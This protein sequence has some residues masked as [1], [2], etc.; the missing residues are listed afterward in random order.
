MM[1]EENHIVNLKTERT[2][3]KSKI[4]C[5]A[6]QIK[7]IHKQSNPDMAKVK[8]IYDSLNDAYQVFVDINMQYEELVN[9]DE[10]YNSYIKVNNLTS[11][12]FLDKIEELYEESTTLY[13][14]VELSETTKVE[15][16]KLE[17]KIRDLMCFQQRAEIWLS[18]MDD[19]TNNNNYKFFDEIDAFLYE[20]NR[21]CESFSEF[22]SV[23]K[24]VDSHQMLKEAD[25]CIFKLEQ[26]LFVCKKIYAN[27]QLSSDRVVENST[28]PTYND[29]DQLSVRDGKHQTNDSS[30][31]ALN[32]NSDDRE[33]P[34]HGQSLIVKPNDHERVTDAVSNYRNMDVC[35]HSDTCDATASMRGATAQ[36]NSGENF[37]Y[38]DTVS[39]RSIV[40][41]YNQKP[42]TH[43]R[44]GA[45]LVS[46]RGGRLQSLG[47]SGSKVEQSAA[48]FQPPR[49]LFKCS[50]P[51]VFD[52]DRRQWPEFRSIWLRYAETGFSEDIDKAFALKKAIKGRPAE[53]IKAI[54]ANQPG[55]FQRM[56]DRLDAVYFDNSMCIQAAESDLARLRP[57]KEEDLNGLVHFINEVESIYSQLGEVDQLLSI[58][59]RQVDNLNSLLPYHLRREWLSIYY[60]LPEYEKVHPFSRFMLFLEGERDIVLRL[61]EHNQNHSKRSSGPTKII[62][63]SSKTFHSSSQ[64]SRSLPP[65]THTSV[66]KCLI[67]S[68]FPTSHDTVNCSEFKAMAQNKRYQVVLRGNACF[69]CLKRGHLRQN[70]YNWVKCKLCDSNTHHTLLCKEKPDGIEEKTSPN[71]SNVMATGCHTSDN[72]TGVLLPIQSVSVVDTNNKVSLF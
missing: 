48:A 59:L 63:S 16:K 42:M 19:D 25:E 26:K 35:K 22:V 1:A 18:R 61:S 68:N 70:C 50:A 41:A 10:K 5:H 8:D 27:N 52:G 39:R 56:W 46:S 66:P 3:L 4:T 49:S 28:L 62:Q 58:T 29:D 37:L 60:K 7:T 65:K 47:S 45:Q 30:P 31:I 64:A 51:P 11:E 6:K 33:L 40:G 57:V 21:F 72:K 15:K 71:S 55:A 67:H 17:P 44:E 54:Y 69:R 43:M 13:Y 24:Y 53:Y 12:E 32:L 38:S 14:E 34:A 36:V 9:S 23:F 20:F 2:K